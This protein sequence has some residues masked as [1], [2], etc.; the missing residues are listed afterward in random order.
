MRIVRRSGTRS[1]G[2]VTRLAMAIWRGSSA[3]M[4]LVVLAQV[5][6][7]AEGNLDTLSM[8]MSW[9]HVVVSLET[10]PGSEL[11][12]LEFMCGHSGAHGGIK[13]SGTL[14]G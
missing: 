6:A 10:R 13:L 8:L 4:A 5:R 12:Q 11:R 1:A 14:A 2:S 3:A 7:I 9:S